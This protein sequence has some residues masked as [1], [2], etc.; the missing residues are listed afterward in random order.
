VGASL[1]PA[2]ASP[3]DPGPSARD[4][5]TT[6]AQLPPRAELVTPGGL[7][8]LQRAIGNAAMGRLLARW[9]PK[10]GPDE[11][12]PIERNFELD[13]STFVKSMDAPAERETGGPSHARLPEKF[14]PGDHA[15]YYPHPDP[16]VQRVFIDQNVPRDV[17]FPG[18]KGEF[19]FQDQGDKIRNF[20]IYPS[21]VR[22][23]KP[24]MTGGKGSMAWLNNNPGNLTY[25][26]HDH[27]Q[28]SGK[29]NWHSFYIFPDHATGR[30][31]IPTWLKQNGYWP[32][33]ILL[34]IQKYA[35]QG[36][37]KNKPDV[38]AQQIVDALA[39]TKTSKGEDVTLE[40]TLQDLTTDQMTKVQDAIERVEGTI[41]GWPHSRTDTALPPEILSRL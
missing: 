39:G 11:P 10:L 36:D 29:L 22:E 9:G 40:T 5:V 31:A 38:Y 15:W 12:V 4:A 19:D 28:Y 18:S 23:G 27:G 34:T 2:A 37:G 33:S 7:P 41:E 13:P 1:D 20:V 26:G 17:W 30:A 3:E 16:K 24:Q 25:D 6:P 14:Q 21:E 32:R 8:A 35:P